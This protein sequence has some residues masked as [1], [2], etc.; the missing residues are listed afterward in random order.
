[1]RTVRKEYFLTIGEIAEEYKRN[2]RDV[3]P[4]LLNAFWMGRFEPF[5]REDRSPYSLISRLALLE[6]WRD[7]GDHPSIHFST[8]LEGE[9]EELP[10][11]VVVDVCTWIIYPLRQQTGPPTICRLLMVGSQVSAS[12]ISVMNA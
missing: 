12:P 2:G 1:M 8:S 5:V 3:L 4:A 7:L 6:A 9:F 10:E 11:R